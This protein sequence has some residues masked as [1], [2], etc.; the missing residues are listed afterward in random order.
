MPYNINEL[1]QRAAL[2]ALSE[3]EISYQQIQTILEQKSWVLGELQKLDWIKKIY[4]SDA[5]FFLV[6]T[7]NAPQGPL[8]TERNLLTNTDFNNRFSGWV[9]LGW[10][11]ELSEQPSGQTMIVNRV[12]EPSLALSRW[13]GG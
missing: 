1:T 9:M 11:I 4:P 5:N 3:K 10:N 13:L 6:K 2:K 12:G 7:E 8:E